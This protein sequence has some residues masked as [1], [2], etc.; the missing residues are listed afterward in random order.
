MAEDM[1]EMNGY[2]PEQASDLYVASGEMCDWVYGELSVYCFTF[3]LSPSSGYYGGF[4]PGA[5]IIDKVFNDNWA[6]M[7]YLAKYADNPSRVLE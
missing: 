1:A 3:E 7:L 5:S 2:T 6:P 4:Y